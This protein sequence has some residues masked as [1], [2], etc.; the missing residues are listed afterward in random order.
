MDEAVSGI[1]DATL[2]SL[3]DHIEG[4]E[5]QKR[6]LDEAIKEIYAEAKSAGF[7]P[8]FIRVIVEQRLMDKDD[9]DEQ[10]S[11]IEVCRRARGM[12]V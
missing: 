7:E 2:K 6:E 10:E 8:A 12:G 1:A 3:I 4:L 11:L 9:L 5:A